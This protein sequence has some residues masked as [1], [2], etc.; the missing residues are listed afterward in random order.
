MV[1]ATASK[2]PARGR[3]SSA[4]IRVAAKPKA[5]AKTTTASTP[6]SDAA[7]MT[8][9]GARL[10]KK[11]RRP[12]VRAASPTVA[13]DSALTPASS[14]RPASGSIGQTASRPSPARIA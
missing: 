5:T 13:S 12:S 8:L 7:L 4:L 10:A 1:S 2:K 14:P 11:A 9:A 6:S 3:R